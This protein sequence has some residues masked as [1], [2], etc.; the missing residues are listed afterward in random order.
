[1]QAANSN[2]RLT[3]ISLTNVKSSDGL[4][5]AVCDGLSRANK[6]LPCRYFYDETGSEIFE[7]IC[8]LPEYY[9]T[10]AEHE[11]LRDRADDI[12]NAF[13]G[14]TTLVELGSGSST[15][16]RELIEAFLKCHGALKYVPLDISRSMLEESAN[17]LL[18]DYP[19]LEIFAIAA[20]YARGLARIRQEEKSRKL[21][22]FLG[23]SVGNFSRDDA[24]EFLREVRATMRPDDRLLLGIDLRKAPDV[25][26]RAYDDSAGVTARF[27]MNILSRI[28]AELDGDFDLE[29]FTHR[30]V[31]DEDIGRVEMHLVSQV[32]QRVRIGTLDLNVNFEA[33]ES[34]HTE[35]SYKYSH[36]EID[37]L[38]SAAKLQRVAQWFDTGQQFSLSLFAPECSS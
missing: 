35:N 36:R 8:E 26:E 28:N 6:T 3:L 31:V 17:E 33:E 29:A 24:A 7:E 20:E 4:E 9:L 30:A 18:G 1:V 32:S 14:P 37:D 13:E 12:A 15:K 2:K 11:I 10:R 25:L 27:N 21:I 23:S 22:V 16:T 5:E 34:I 19:A 38:A